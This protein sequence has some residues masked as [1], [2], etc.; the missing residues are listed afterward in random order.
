VTRYFTLH[1]KL[2]RAPLKGKLTSAQVIRYGEPQ[3]CMCGSQL[4]PSMPF[5][6]ASL[7][8]FFDHPGTL[9]DTA[10]AECTPAVGP[11]GCAVLASLKRSSTS[12]PSG[13]HST[14]LQCMT[15]AAGQ[16]VAS[17][18]FSRGPTH[19]YLSLG[20]HNKWA[21]SDDA[22]RYN[23][24][25]GRWFRGL[26]ASCMTVILALETARDVTVVPP[27]Y[28]AP[29]GMCQHTNLRVRERNAAALAAFRS[30][31]QRARGRQ[32]CRVL[33]LFS[34]TLPLVFSRHFYSPGDPVHVFRRCSHAQPRCDFI[35]EALMDVLW[36]V[37]R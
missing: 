17:S 37:H 21:S 14:Q 34:A 12:W 23:A 31:C 28:A 5:R 2:L 32:S 10:S 24:A 30:A 19:I 6:C 11:A 26:P 8:H 16:K 36:S 18:L 27:K 29:G 13:N 4:D 33:D 20:S 25:F 22:P 35:G 3:R 9:G 1:S 7:L 15:Q